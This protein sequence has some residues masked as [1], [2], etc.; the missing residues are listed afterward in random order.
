MVHT[1]SFIKGILAVSGSF[2]TLLQS[3]RVDHF[4]YMDII[5]S[6]RRVKY[7]LKVGLLNESIVTP[8]KILLVLSKT[9][10]HVSQM[11]IFL[12]S[13]LEQKLEFEGPEGTEWGLEIAYFLLRG[14]TYQ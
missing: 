9:T 8:S 6:L 2:F 10:F 14:Y 4:D 11:N 1:P 7:S 13:W 3:Q 5:T 12:I